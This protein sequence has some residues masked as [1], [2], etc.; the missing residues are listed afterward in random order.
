MKSFSVFLSIILVFTLLLG[1][2]P[3]VNAAEAELVPVGL[4]LEEADDGVKTIISFTDDCRYIAVGTIDYE[5]TE[6]NPIIERIDSF[7]VSFGDEVILTVEPKD[8]AATGSAEEIC[9]GYYAISFPIPDTTKECFVTGLTPQNASKTQEQLLEYYGSG[10]QF[11]IED[12][13]YIDAEKLASYD[14]GDDLMCWAA[15]ASN[16]LRYSGWGQRADFES[17]D[18][19]FEAMIDAFTDEP[20]FTA[21]GIEWFFC[22][23]QEGFEK[24]LAPGS[25]GYL[26]E[27]DTHTLIEKDYFTCESGPDGTEITGL[28][29]MIGH[30]KGGD[31]VELSVDWVNYDSSHA[32]TAWGCVTDSAYSDNLAA[33]YDSLI[34][35]DSD[36]NE[37]FGDDRR[38]APNTLDLYHLSEI[39]EEYG[40]MV[41]LEYGYSQ[42]AL[43][44]YVSL[45]P[46]SEDIPYETDERATKDHRHD[47]DFKVNNISIQP[48]E[49]FA[50]ASCLKGYE[51]SVYL[52]ASIRNDGVTDIEDM[53]PVRLVVKDAQGSIVLEREAETQLYP[54]TPSSDVCFGNL[55]HL[56][57][58][59]YTAEIDVNPNGE[60]RESLLMNNH[61]SCAFEVVGNKPDVSSVSFSAE[62]GAFADRSVSVTMDYHDLKQ[63]EIYNQSD[64]VVLVYSFFDGEKWSLEAVDRMSALQEEMKF[65]MPF[66]KVRFRLV[67][68]QGDIAIATEA[69]AYDLPFPVV[70]FVSNGADGFTR[71]IALESGARDLVGQSPITFSLIN[72][73]A[74]TLSQIS[75]TLRLYAIDEATG[76]ET[77]LIEPVRA[78]LQN[79]VL[80]DTFTLS[81]WDEPLYGMN[82]IQ[83]RFVDDDHDQY[84]TYQQIAIFRAKER[85]SAVVTTADDLNDPYDGLTSLREAAA[86]GEKNGGTVTFSDMI[87]TVRLNAPIQVDKTVVI[88]G[89]QNVESGGLCVQING[90]YRNSLFDIAGGSLTLRNIILSCCE[91]NGN[92]GAILCEGGTL[93]TDHVLIE[94]CRAENG[95]GIYFDGGTGRL[96]NTSF[97]ICK[98]AYGA[99]VYI[100]NDAQVDMLNCTLVSSYISGDGAVYN[101]SGRLNMISSAVIGCD[102]ISSEISVFNAVCSE[103]E[104]NIVNSILTDTFAPYHSASGDI[105]IY[106]SA[107]E[108][109]GDGVATDALTQSYA[110]KQLIPSEVYYDMPIV[111]RDNDHAICYPEL[112][113]VAENGCLTSAVDGKLILSKDGETVRTGIDTPFTNEELHTDMRGFERIS[114]VYGPCVSITADL[115]GDANLD[116]EVDITDATTIQRYDIGLTALS[117]RALALS[118]VDKDGYVCIIDA[119]WI[120]R[121]NLNMIAPEGIGEPIL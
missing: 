41:V 87:G 85:E 73:S 102:V 86:Y 112:T 30:L 118:D 58:G 50:H 25:G 110:P 49:G 90:R 104:T 22:G 83:A 71:E 68:F 103:G 2:V 77:E 55:D 39:E 80:S 64:R 53:L 54:S 101:H 21:N 91:T 62:I 19:I 14:D 114:G 33:H 76:G 37:A 117:D 72:R 45:K 70:Q 44:G 38:S 98:A 115:L 40:S 7:E 81:S 89:L 27:Y 11:S 108:T 4:C 60:V 93:V 57:S 32:V 12:L 23:L 95:G 18:D 51:G 69:V 99:A 61:Y 92:G 63:T 113:S 15:A 66:S 47:P 116:G 96:L 75:G 119:T 35:S 5:S 34:I 65:Y 17:E 6:K 10:E 31:A 20:G 46:Y 9:N 8:I 120:Q 42:G 26:P 106:C 43:S 74:E 84:T 97:S 16:M 59:S 1:T 78:V 3:F 94:S 79:G 48:F 36:N 24:L 121:W 107:V 105:H 56:T 52:Y 100:D 13:E 109:V 28:K 88:D 111:I 29:E 67:F 82:A